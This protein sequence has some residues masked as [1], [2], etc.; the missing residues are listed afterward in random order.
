M[1]QPAAYLDVLHTELVLVAVN[2]KTHKQQLK[3]ALVGA[4]ATHYEP[5]VKVSRAQIRTA[6]LEVRLGQGSVALCSRWSASGRCRR[7]RNGV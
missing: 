6:E 5:A 2:I 3:T 7:R 1:I 4:P